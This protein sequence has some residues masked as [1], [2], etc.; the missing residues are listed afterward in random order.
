MFRTRMLRLNLPVHFVVSLF[1]HE[2]F[3]RWF[4]KEAQDG[5]GGWEVSQEVPSWMLFERGR[6]CSKIKCMLNN[7]RLVIRQTYGVAVC[8]SLRR[9]IM[10]PERV[11]VT[12]IY[13]N[14]GM[15][16]YS[17]NLFQWHKI[18]FPLWI[19]FTFIY[20]FNGNP[21]YKNRSM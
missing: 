1:S 5:W 19:R 3:L 2:T 8:I 12:Y 21:E 14:R 15:Y 6:S 20:V 9:S 4:I 11:R 7:V 17:Y 16:K 13:V 18:K 10:R